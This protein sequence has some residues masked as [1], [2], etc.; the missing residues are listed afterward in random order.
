MVALDRGAAPGFAVIA[1][2][3]NGRSLG[4]WEW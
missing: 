1:G 3:L 2:G 4:A